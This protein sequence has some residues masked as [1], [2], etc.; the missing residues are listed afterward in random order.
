MDL[1]GLPLDGAQ[2]PLLH[3]SSVA[4]SSASASPPVSPPLFPISKKEE[5][6]LNLTQMLH[7]MPSYQDV[8]FKPLE[9]AKPFAP[10]IQLP[11]GA[12]IESS[13]SLFSLFISEELIAL[14]LSNTNKY[15]KAKNA[16]QAG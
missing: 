5:K 16:G 12:D 4:P 1:W 7:E 3:S 10:T 11:P 13:Y 9:M 14:L 2:E 8:V 6:K 15:A